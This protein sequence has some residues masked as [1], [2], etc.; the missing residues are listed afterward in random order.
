MKA[1]PR[2]SLIHELAETIGADDRFAG[3]TIRKGFPADLAFA[4]PGISI[5]FPLEER[6]KARRRVFREDEIDED[7]VAVIF[8]RERCEFGGTME[9]W[10]KTK[11]EREPLELAL[12]HL[13]GGDEIAAGGFE[14]PKPPGLSIVLSLLYDAKVRVRLVDKDVQDAQSASGGYFRLAYSLEASVPDLLRVEYNKAVWTNT[15][16]EF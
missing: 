8:E 14:S 15:V 1:T 12:D 5:E 9:L 2:D 11:L 6:V 4:Y 10:T 16:S 7:T 3:V 13:L